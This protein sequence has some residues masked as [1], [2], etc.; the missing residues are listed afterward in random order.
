MNIK[1]TSRHFK[2]HESLNEYAMAA[3]ETLTRFYDGITRADVVL[4]FEKTK[5]STKVAE[6]SI[7]VYKE[8]LTG[9]GKTAEFEKSID[10]AVEKVRVQLTRYKDKLHAKDRKSGREVR[11]KE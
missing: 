11:E 8:V 2:A 5:K 6:V 4:V 10:A 1:V 3:V 7:K 9:I